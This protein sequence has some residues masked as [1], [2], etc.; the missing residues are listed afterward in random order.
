MTFDKKLLQLR[1]QNKFSQESLAERLGVSRQSV[2]KWELGTC[3]PD[4]DL[5]IKISDIFA[6]TLDALLKEEGCQD[7][8]LL[9]SD[10]KENRFDSDFLVFLKKAKYKTYAS[11]AGHVESSRINSVDLSFKSTPYT[12]LDTYL[13]RT[14]FAGEEAV[15]QL[16]HP[17]WSMNYMG[18]VLDEVFSG[19]FLKESLRN[20]PDECPLRGPV[21]YAKGNYTYLCDVQGDIE[22]F[23]GREMI[24]LGDKKI[25]ECYFHGGK[26]I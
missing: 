26:I 18:R 22:W 13:G 14:Q 3:M 21:Y 7:N 12:Y 10:R 8:E 6:V 20:T 11:N 17:I 4:V 23:Q 16:E 5:I 24:F 1:Q 19:D 15:W 9:I 2:S 25:Y